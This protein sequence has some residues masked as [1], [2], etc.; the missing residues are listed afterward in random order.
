M[1]R[2]IVVGYDDT[3]QAKDALA[4][5]RQ[6]ADATGAA[7]IAAGMVAI[8]S[9]WA[10]VD[11]HLGDA[12]AQFARRLD[13]AAGAAHARP[14]LVPSSS[15][16]RGLHELA[17]TI[18]VDLIIVG[19]ASHGHLSGSLAGTTAVALLRGSPCA[20]A[21]APRGYRKHA[22]GGINAVVTGFDGS[23]ESGEA[24]LTA[25]RLAASSGAKLKLL[26]VAVP[27]PV[28]GL[29]ERVEDDARVQLAEACSAI[30]NG[31]E[32][33]ATLVSGDPVR[34]LAGVANVPGSLLVVGSR[35]YGPL[36]RVVLG[37]VASSLVG[38]ARCPLIITPRGLDEPD[39]T[40]ANVALETAS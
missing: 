16:A 4:L 24:L 20:V 36:R 32:V 38:S 37:S 13:E 27:P 34:A 28:P 33:E 17:E 35:G 10:G 30:P 1:Y 29:L 3:E 39:D 40:D 18:G 31:V 7:L 23:A 19:S 22:G 9:M 21:I 11:A 14:E 15:P 8:D 25:S 6:L 5:G 12:D 2:K 26:S